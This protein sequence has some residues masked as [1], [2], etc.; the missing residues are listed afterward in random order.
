L[1]YRENEKKG[2]FFCVA[3]KKEKGPKKIGLLIFFG[4]FIWGFFW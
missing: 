3:W 1:V 4:F 2:I